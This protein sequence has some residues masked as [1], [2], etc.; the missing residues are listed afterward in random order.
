MSKTGKAHE[1]RKKNTFTPKEQGLLHVYDPRGTYPTS[2]IVGNKAAL[3]ALRDAVERALRQKE[4]SPVVV[5]RLDPGDQETY[6]LV[7]E[8]SDNTVD[9][10]AAGEQRLAALDKSIHRNGRRWRY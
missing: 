1:R 9:R 5:P 10:L 8:R 7:V 2:Y 4:P 6:R 3:E